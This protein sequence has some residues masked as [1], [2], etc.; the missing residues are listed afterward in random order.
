LVSPGRIRRFVE[1]LAG[2]GPRSYKDPE[3]VAKTVEFLSGELTSLGYHV[4][5]E[6]FGA[7]PGDLNLCVERPGAGQPHHVLE[8]GAH[9]DTVPGSPGANDNAS[10][11]A[12]VLELAHILTTARCRRSIRL[13][14]FGAE[15]RGLAGSRAH[16]NR[17]D[18]EGI[19]SSG[20][21]VLETI[22]CRRVEPGSQRTPLR[23]PWLYDPP[24]RGDFIAAI[25]NSR[26]RG[27]V[28]S[29]QRAAR[30]SSPRLSV[31]ASKHLHGWIREAARS[32]HVPY[33]RAGR[34]AMMLTDTANFRSPH[35]HQPSD[36]PD[37]VNF[38][39]LADV[40]RAVARTAIDLA[41]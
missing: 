40:I 39:F 24:D 13:C 22:G 27:L 11:V 8:V 19:S 30:A 37:Q 33:W 20:I 6:R 31:F 12:G 7:E 16:V 21:I 34:E 23:I 10:G 4:E 29:F 5:L 18:Q 38:E 14:L 1:T 25:S 26:S 3:A 41:V 2:F 35:Y 17:L 32:D 15:E 28:N 36:S 9:Y